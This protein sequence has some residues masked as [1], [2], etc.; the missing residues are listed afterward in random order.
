MEDQRLWY[1]HPIHSHVA[2]PPYPPFCQ[3]PPPPAGPYQLPP[4]PAGPYQP[5][6]GHYHHPAPVHYHLH[7]PVNGP[8]HPYSWMQYAPAYYLPEG[9]VVPVRRVQELSYRLSPEDIPAAGI[10]ILHF[11]MEPG[12]DEHDEAGG[13]GSDGEDYDEDVDAYGD[14]DE[15]EDQGLN[16]RR[17]VVQAPCL[18]DGYDDE[19]Q[20]IGE[21]ERTVVDE[22]EGDWD[23]PPRQ[24]RKPRK[25]RRPYTVT[26]SLRKTNFFELSLEWEDEHFRTLYRMSK[27]TFWGVVDRIKYSREFKSKGSKSQRPVFYQLGVFLIRY[28][29]SGSHFRHP[30]LLTSIGEG[31]V[32]LYCRRVIRAVREYGLECVVWPTAGEK[33][34]IK[35]QFKQLCG[36]D[37]IIGSLDGTH[38]G[39]E[40]RPRVAGSAYISRKK[41]L[42]V[43]VQAIVKPNGQFIAFQSGWAGS[44]PD[45]SA[46]PDMHV[47]LERERLFA[48]GEFLLAD[49]G[50]PPSPWVLI[51]YARNELGADDRRRRFNNQISKAR[52]VVEWA[53][54]RLKARFPALRRL[55][56]VRNMKDIY[57]AI[58]ATMVL[59][60]MCYQLGDSPNG[61]QNPPENDREDD[62]EEDEEGGQE[63]WVDNALDDL[64]HERRAGKRFREHCLG[65][66]CPA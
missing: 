10:S 59:H 65:I 37:G 35:K 29:I 47:Y 28:G 40:T 50:Y 31:T 44:R 6:F 52:V 58:E 19:A 46:W 18:E 16:A 33:E 56:A 4:P 17:G 55:G 27:A 14:I 60:N 45:I 39:L 15:D 53:F 13:E 51:P 32:V 2:Y 23:Q 63:P 24:R 30:K 20:D 34:Q 12:V 21:M 41:T 22:S 38:C 66:I 62:I 49:G 7:H 1:T 48:P 43:N 8:F 57:R 61:F 11:A 64:N 3:P 42:S 25:P 54:G 5:P 36:L 9:A 26:M